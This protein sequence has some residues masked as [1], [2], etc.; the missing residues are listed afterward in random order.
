M[1]NN[2]PVQFFDLFKNAYKR[3]QIVSIDRP[4]VFKAQIGKEVVF[5]ED[6]LDGAL[7]SI[8]NPQKCTADPRNACHSVIKRR[9]K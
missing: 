7:C 6:G 5:K 9:S 1:Y 8:D 2:R 3:G 4:Y